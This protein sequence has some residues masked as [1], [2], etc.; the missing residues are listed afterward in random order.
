MIVQRTANLQL[1]IGVSWK[2]ILLQWNLKIVLL[3]PVKM[4]DKVHGSCTILVCNA[5]VVVPSCMLGSSQQK[6]IALLQSLK[7]KLA[8]SPPA[9]GMFEY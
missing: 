2:W 9:K 7:Q 8:V 5:L 1:R 6:E 4:R 3:G